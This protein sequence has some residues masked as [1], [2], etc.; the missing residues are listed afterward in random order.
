MFCYWPLTE[1]LELLSYTDI[2]TVAL[3][4]AVAV[5]K[6]IEDHYRRVWEFPEELSAHFANID[7]LST[8]EVDSHVRDL[9]RRIPFSAWVGLAY[10]ASV[11]VF[12]T[13]YKQFSDTRLDPDMEPTRLPPRSRA[14]LS[15]LTLWALGERQPLDHCLLRPI[16]DLM[17]LEAMEL[18][19]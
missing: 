1:L 11:N 17:D 6:A 10:G 9:W 3:S 5:A 8:Y 16:R 7:R 15:P 19:I 4:K 13:L 18:T 12:E 14:S 2:Q